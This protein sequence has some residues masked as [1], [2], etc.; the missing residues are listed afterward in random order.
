MNRYFFRR[1]IWRWRAKIR[2]ATPTSARSTIA[3][4]LSNAAGSGTYAV[5]AVTPPEFRNIKNS[6]NVL[7]NWGNPTL[8]EVYLKHFERNYRQAVAFEVRY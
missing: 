4:A 8:A 1:T 3:T 6:E 5:F 2:G 7:V